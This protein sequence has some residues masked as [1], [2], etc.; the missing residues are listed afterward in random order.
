LKLK[1]L[2]FHDSHGST[3]FLV[4]IVEH[5]ASSENINIAEIIH[6]ILAIFLVASK[7]AFATKLVA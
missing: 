4:A 5:P 6:A 3:G 1:T 7:M 2:L